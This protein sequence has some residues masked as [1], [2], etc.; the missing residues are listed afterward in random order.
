MIESITKSLSVLA[1]VGYAVFGQTE[2]AIL[3][4]L[5]AIYISINAKR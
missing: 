3:C 1:A 5:Y 4:M 2:Y